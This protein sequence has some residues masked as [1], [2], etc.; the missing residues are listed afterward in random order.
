MIRRVVLNN[1]K[2]FGRVTFDVPGHLVLA[3][4]NNTGK[5][6]LLQAIA[7]WSHALTQWRPGGSTQ[8]Y[9]GGVFRKH[10]IGRGD[11]SAVPVRALD[12]LWHNR[13]CASTMEISVTH[14]SGWTVTMEFIWDT[15]EQ[16][17]VRPAAAT[18]DD[19]LARA[20]LSPV[21]VP[22]TSGVLRDEPLHQDPYIALIIGQARPGDVIRNILVRASARGEGWTKLVEVVKELFGYELQV[23]IATGAYIRAE[24][25]Q[26]PGGPTFDIA[27]AGSGFQ[28]VLLLF[29]MLQE[30]AGALLLIDEPD[31]HLHIILQEVVWSRL[32]RL[33]AETGSQL[34]VATH[35]ETFIDAV[36]PREL[37]LC[38]ST[39]RLL[40]S[41]AE[42][43]RL[44]ESLRTLNNTD[45]MRVGDA[46]G[47][48]YTDDYTDR[49]ILRAWA[50]VL[51]HPLARHL[52]QGIMWHPR[53]KDVAVG[54]PGIT[55]KQHFDALRLVRP[56]LKGVDLLDGD[57]RG[58]VTPPGTQPNGPTVLRWDR[59]EIESYLYHPDALERF[60]A[61]TLGMRADSDAFAPHKDALR[62]WIMDNLPPAVARD[63]LGNHDYLNSTKARTALIPP[64][65]EAGGLPSFPYTRYAEIAARMLPHE[66][67]S[68]V[69]AKLDAILGALS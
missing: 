44:T 59:Y 50:R 33:A 60:I 1:F 66:L 46:M 22:A 10:P 7:A 58:R 2:R 29:A 41:A 61:H 39:P 18:S 45:L 57:A 47:V 23:P 15:S 25:A 27:S 34:I 12:L 19:D 35:A 17:Y 9:R 21:F 8:R 51:G 42:R 62:A 13:S 64:I 49:E 16:M 6:T 24:Y 52:D 53:A 48:L 28:Q 65:L 63:P 56:N 54:T 5:T 14:T 11:F 4:P 37:C 67:P 3:G 30:R 26:T 31:A 32:R 20:S 55:S 43:D 38:Y 69:T 36:E 68:E 40:S